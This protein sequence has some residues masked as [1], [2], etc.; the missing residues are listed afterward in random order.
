M[1]YIVETYK[2]IFSCLS[3]WTHSVWFILLKHTKASSV[4]YQF[5]HIQY[6]LYC[7]NIQRHLQLFISLNP[8]SMI[9]IVETY[10]DIFS[11]FIFENTFS[12]MIYIVETYKDIFS[13]LS[14][15]THSVW[16]ILLK[17]TKTSSVVYQFE[18][19]QYDL[20][21]WNIQR[22]LQLFI[23]LNTFSM[24]YIVETYKCIFSCLS[25]WTHSVWFI[26]PR[27]IKTYKHNCR[28]MFDALNHCAKV[29]KHAKA[30]SVVHQFEQIQY[31]LYCWNIQ[32]HLQLFIS[33]NTFSMIYIVE[34]YKDI[35]SYLSLW[36]HSAW[37]ILLK[38]INTSSVDYYFFFSLNIK[39][40]DL[41]HFGNMIV[42]DPIFHRLF[43]C[44]NTKNMINIV[45]IQSKLKINSRYATH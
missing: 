41:N 5:E 43:I 28:N 2:D 34:S 11:W 8:F 3:V 26:L 23:C 40:Y 22:H 21:C 42:N 10:K 14:V 37:F 1:I 24:I 19:I 29:T 16:F 25:V 6:D 7:W 13:C 17:H 35:F 12:C 44:L 9:Y 4:V 45:D 33:L 39:R 15:W 36:T 18:H 30:S 20:Y 38:H 31:D 32:R 27:H